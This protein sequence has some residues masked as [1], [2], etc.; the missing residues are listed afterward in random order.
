MEIGLSQSQVQKQILSPQMIQSMEILVLNSQQL[1]ERIEEALE[2][3]VALEMEEPSGGDDAQADAAGDDHDPVGSEAGTEG[4]EGGAPDAEGPDAEAGADERFEL[5]GQPE[6]DQLADRYEHLAE[7]QSEEYYNAPGSRNGVSGE[8]EDDRFEALQNAADRPPSLQ[9]H[10]IDQLRMRTEVDER[11]RA[12]CVE[13][14]Y[15]LDGNGRLLY[16]LE[17]LREALHHAPPAAA[18]APHAQETQVSPVALPIAPEEMTAALDVLKSLDPPGVG[19]RDLEECLLFQLD[20][21]GQDYALERLLIQK[22]LR[23]VARNRLP[24]VAKATGRT[25][26]EVKAAVELIASLD[27]NPGHGFASAENSVV[28]PDVIVEEME[29]EYRVQVDDPHVPRLRISPYYRQLLEES[30]NDPELRKYIKKK[31]DS[32]EWLMHAIHQRKSTLQRVAEEVVQHQ[33]EFFRGGVRALRPLKMQEIADRIGVNVSTVSRAIS[34]KYFQAPG[35]IRELKFLFTGGTL[36]DDGSTESRGSV[37]ERIKTL[38][39]AEN[40]RRP[41]SDSKIVELLAKE[42]IHISRRTV[43]KYREAENILSSRERRQY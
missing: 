40:S 7:F 30:R 43:T 2:E 1:E 22:H 4:G 25:L 28:R 14:I 27:P 21:D 11:V 17:E 37:I 41:L 31:I 13:L 20:R 29:G 3:N 16:P 23:D 32:A 18:D 9:E 24:A 6:V 5:D 39:A 38:V 10:L 26:D 12:L 33:Q 34:G 42:G 15:N 35:T 36:K 19:A 8:D